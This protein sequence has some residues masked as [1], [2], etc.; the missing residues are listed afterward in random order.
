MVIT[1]FRMDGVSGRLLMVDVV[2]TVGVE[3]IP[4]NVMDATVNNPLRI[5]MVPVGVLAPLL[6]MHIKVVM[7]V[8][9]EP[10]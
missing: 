5:L 3:M 1:T 2:Y 8:M 6:M 7:G 9:R 10:G 4:S